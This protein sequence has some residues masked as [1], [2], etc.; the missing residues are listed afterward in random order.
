MTNRFRSKERTV[1]IL[2]G[3]DLIFLLC[4]L[5]INLLSNYSDLDYLHVHSNLKK[6]PVTLILKKTKKVTLCKCQNSSLGSS[7]TSNKA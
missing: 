2:K 5:S 3:Q 6:P 7:R 4:N 1:D